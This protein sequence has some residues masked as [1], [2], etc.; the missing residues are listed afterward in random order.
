MSKKNYRYA[1][2]K[3]KKVAGVFAHMGERFGVD[4][5][6][7][8]VGFVASF[9]F[10]SWEIL[11]VAYLAAGIYFSVQRKREVDAGGSRDEI[12]YRQPRG[13][14]HDLRTK[15]DETDR[16]LMA[17]DH[18]LHNAESDALAREIEALKE[19]K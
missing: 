16:R 11:L 18:H 14:T 10:I 6:F 9:L 4:P 17:I 8:R 13:S 19:A 7:L 15:L 1:L 2:S 5:T 12:A 3:D